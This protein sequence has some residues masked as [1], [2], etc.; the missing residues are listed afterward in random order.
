MGKHDTKNDARATS[1][2]SFMPENGRNNVEGKPPAV[3][4]NSLLE[5]CDSSL[6]DEADIWTPKAAQSRGVA[7][8]RAAAILTQAD[9]P[10]FLQG[11]MWSL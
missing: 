6:E 1:P 8:G 7:H 2:N 10:A 5:G 4:S 3:K 9:V 11:D